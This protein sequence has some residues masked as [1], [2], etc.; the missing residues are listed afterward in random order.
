MI[1][2][3]ICAFAN[4]DGG[5]LPLEVDDSGRIVCM[6]ADPEAVQRRLTGFLQ[7]GCSV[8]VTARCGM[9][10]GLRQ[11]SSSA[12]ANDKLLHSMRGIRRDGP[13]IDGHRRRGC[14]RT[15]GRASEPRGGMVPPPRMAGAIP[16]SAARGD[17]ARAR[18]G[19]GGPRSRNESVANTMVVRRMRERRGRSWPTMRRILRECDGTEPELVNAQGAGSSGGPSVSNRDRILRADS[20]FSMLVASG[21]KQQAA[22]VPVPLLGA[23]RPR[24]S[25]RCMKRPLGHPRI[26]V[27]TL[28]STGAS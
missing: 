1:G 25:Y 21:R 17:T 11:E 2:M 9:L 24:S 3:V 28:E 22:P 8:P 5:S 10:T 23:L 4:G 27:K 12:S 15:A 7:S 13:R 16:R 19:G 20:E 14:E 6:R 26:P 18:Q